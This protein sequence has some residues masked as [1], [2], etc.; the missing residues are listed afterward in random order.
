MSPIPRSYHL[1]GMLE[2]LGMSR[3]TFSRAG[4]A[5]HIRM[6]AAGNHTHYDAADVVEW[7]DRLAR[8]RASIRLGL[9]PAKTPLVEAPRFDEYDLDCPQCGGLA[10][11]KPPQTEEDWSAWAALHEDDS[12]EYPAACSRCEWRSAGE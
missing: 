5:A 2:R 6:C 7:A 1:A 4:L 3:S 10:L 12:I 11:W 9:L 8:R